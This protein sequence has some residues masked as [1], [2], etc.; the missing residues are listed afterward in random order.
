[1][2]C[3]WSI[4]PGGGGLCR[5]PN[6]TSLSIPPRPF[7]AMP[8]QPSDQKAETSLT[9]GVCRIQPTAADC[10]GC[11]ESP[12]CPVRQYPTAEADCRRIELC[13][14]KNSKDQC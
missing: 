4:T 9:K 1:M 8:Q 12:D 10:A 3:F 7:R 6:V 5:L 11:P 2:V 14:A 13:P